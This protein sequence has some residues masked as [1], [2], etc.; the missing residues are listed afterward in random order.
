MVLAFLLHYYAHSIQKPSKDASILIPRSISVPLVA[1]SRELGIAPVLTFADTVLW[2]WEFVNPQESL[3]VNNIRY[4]NLL[5]GSETEQAFYV[6]SAAVELK[7]VEMLQIIEGFMN[8][9][10]TSELSAVTKI[11]DDLLR[12]KKIVDE[13][14]DIFQSVRET[15]DPTEF[16]WLCR[17]WWSGSESKPNSQPT[18]IFEDVPDYAKLDLSGPS[19]GQST[20]MHALDVFLDI[21]HKLVHHHR[22][23]APSDNNKKADRGFMERMRR[24]MPGKHREY[25]TRVGAV[26]CS[27]RAVANLNPGLREPYNGAVDALKRLRD[28]HIRIACIYVVTKTNSTPPPQAG[29]VSCHGQ[30]PEDGRARG[31]GGNQVSSLLKAGRDATNRAKLPAV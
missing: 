9:P 27:V 30:G 4:V 29:I 22:Q 31:T 6:V 11:K 18:W 26:P 8:L 20:V 14:T 2:N 21:D 24:Y 17:P 19:A 15:V 12:L 23:P 25:L 3:S 16:Y 10:N 13:L 5:S 1:V 7:G 28:I